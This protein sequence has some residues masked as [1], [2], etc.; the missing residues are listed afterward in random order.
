MVFIFFNYME[1]LY[2]FPFV[3][4]HLLSKLGKLKGNCCVCNRI[5]ENEEC[6]YCQECNNF[7]FCFDCSKH[8]SE[9]EMLKL[10]PHKLKPTKRYMWSCDKCASTVYSS[11]LSMCCINCDFDVCV[12]CFWGLNKIEKIY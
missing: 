4:K 11:G 12:N 8:A 6:Y 5:N 9:E 10:H 1:N 2:K 3:H 7:Y